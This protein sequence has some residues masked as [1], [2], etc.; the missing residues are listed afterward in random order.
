MVDNPFATRHTRPGAI[1]FRFAQDCSVAAI[2]DRLHANGGMG[3]IVGPH[4]SG[5]STLLAALESELE[6]A[7]TRVLHIELHDGQRRL[8]IRI[9]DVLRRSP[10]DIIVVD[11]Y[12]QLSRFCRY[13]LHAFCQKHRLGLIVTSHT[14]VHLPDLF[15]TDVTLELAQRIVAGL[16]GKLW[17]GECPPTITP[18]VIADRLT[19][20]QGN[21]RE[22]LMDLYSLYEENNHV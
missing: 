17:A 15:H 19:H 13:R 21:L 16:L 22:V 7:G 3:Q 5:K 11:G 2:V 10:F 8:P 12:E 4:G 1:P 14:S 6:R 18:E 20:H 9:G